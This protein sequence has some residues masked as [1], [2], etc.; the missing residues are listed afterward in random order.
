MHNFLKSALIPKSLVVDLAIRY[1]FEEEG[2]EEE[3]KGPL[4][5]FQLSC[6]NKQESLLFVAFEEGSVFLVYYWRRGLHHFCS[7]FLFCK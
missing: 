6:L 4:N 5:L 2:V 1:R 7:A 3:L